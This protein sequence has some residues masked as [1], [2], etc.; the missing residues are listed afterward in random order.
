[1]DK[2]ING[3]RYT[4]FKKNVDISTISIFRAN[5]IQIYVHKKCLTKSVYLNCIDYEY[6][7]NTKFLFPFSLLIKVTNLEIILNNKTNI[8]SEILRIIDSYL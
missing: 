6:S 4:F 8:P 3:N 2:L 5:L 1:M 7:K